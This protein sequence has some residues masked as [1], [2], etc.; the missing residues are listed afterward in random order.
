MIGKIYIAPLHRLPV[1]NDAEAFKLAVKRQRFV[2][3]NM[4]KFGKI[5]TLKSNG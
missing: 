3:K 2:L 1:F 5:V 4:E